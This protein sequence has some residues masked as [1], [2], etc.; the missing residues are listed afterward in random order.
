MENRDCRNVW[1][2]KLDSGNVRRSRGL[3]R[4]RP[5]DEVE[6]DLL[7]HD[8]E[9]NE[10]EEEEEEEEDDLGV[11]DMFRVRGCKRAK[12]ASRVH[13]PLSVSSAQLPFSSP[14]LLLSSFGPSSFAASSSP[15]P[16]LSSFCSDE[17]A[18]QAALL[19]RREELRALGAANEADPLTDLP[20][21]PARPIALLVSD[22]D[23]ALV[24]F[25]LFS[26]HQLVL[27]KGKSFFKTLFHGKFLLQQAEI[28]S[29]MTQFSN[30]Y[31]LA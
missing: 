20:L 26:L 28:D 10:E 23:G 21:D 6:E 15:S 5:D 30:Y 25:D 16:S 17:W 1:R 19:R 27:R 7:Y 18:H 22:K 12:G 31:G 8:E 4:C 13:A 14:S 29:L 11:R 3:R 24:A 9:G 2:E